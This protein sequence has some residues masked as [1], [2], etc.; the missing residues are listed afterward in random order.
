[1]NQSPLTQQ[2]QD[3]ESSARARKK[4]QSDQA[5]ATMGRLLNPALPLPSA[6]LG[7]GR[8]GEIVAI[9]AREMNF[10]QN[11]V[12]VDSSLSDLDQVDRALA[13]SGVR[14]RRV[15][16]SQDWIELTTMN[17]VVHTSGGLTSGGLAVVVPGS[18][19]RPRIIEVNADPR[20]V[21]SELAREISFTALEVIQP[22]KPGTPRNWD[23]IKLSV[24][25]MR[26]DLTYA[27]LA[28][29]AVGLISLAI[30]IATSLIFSNVVP[31][32]D[33]ARLGIVFVVL[34]LLASA[35]AFFVYL[36]TYQLIR[37]YDGIDMNM[38]GSILDRILRLPMSGLRD[39]SS[40][41]IASKVSL[42]VQLQ[43]AI[44]QAIGV[45]LFAA[46]LVVLN[47]VLMLVLIPSLGAIAILLG[48]ALLG[49]TWYL[50]SRE[51]QQVHAERI[52]SDNL[53]E[54]TLDLVRG[55]VPIRLS[56]GETSGFGR[57]VSS[58]AQ[59]RSAYDARWRY[60]MRTDILRI[61]FIAIM[62]LAFVWT[63]Y[64]LPLGTISSASF[65][66]FLS[67]F[68]QFSFGIAGVTVTIRAFTHALVDTE[69]VKEILSIP[70]EDSTARESPG[71]L[72]GAIELRGVS[73]RYADDFPKVLNDVNFTV[74]PGDFIA[75]VGSSGSGKSTLLRLMLGF[76][77]AT[78]GLVAY[79]DTD[80]SMM[81]LNAV[82]HQFGVV[83]QS[84]LLLPGTIRENISVTTG[85][86]SDAQLWQVLEQ[87]DLYSF[88]QGLPLGLDTVIDEGAHVLSGGQ[89]QRMLLAR[90]LAHAPAV[91]FLDEATSALDNISQKAVSDRIENLGIT[92][93]VIAH[94]LSTIEAADKIIV[95]DKGSVVQTGTYSQL[96]N[97]PGFFSQ[98]VAR[99]EL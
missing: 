2:N 94:R 61:A 62:S 32:G 1:M 43:S 60:E 54:V 5:A 49:A 38:F 75:I 29:V 73:F 57:W 9:L 48:G 8:V 24:S 50:I 18:L 10:T 70:V 67:A 44:A 99:Q 15:T 3:H 66:A 19:R 96:V 14:T 31:E 80:L 59:H 76:E 84:S 30:P 33:T 81:D 22:L 58:F 34:L 55:W 95:L 45:G 16:L 98:L 35:S 74:G 91:L 53:E 25:G 11:P 26:G 90:A 88:V 72:T 27:I 78:Q 97:Q 21:D 42:S 13:A 6:M 52:A 64:L 47:G 36:R 17:M 39:W 37:I 82:R 46:L 68:T 71:M 83:L 63:A 65:L 12:Q 41:R 23:L 85:S 79:D 51:K 89:R 40:A 28:S 56:D 93:I 86:V 92:R 4:N 20:D 87:V 77:A 7:G 69:R